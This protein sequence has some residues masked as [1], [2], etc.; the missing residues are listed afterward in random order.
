M[1]KELSYR[2]MLVV[3]MPIQ[4]LLFLVEKNILG[5]YLDTILSC[6][7]CEQIIYCLIARRDLEEEDNLLRRYYVRRWLK[8]CICCDTSH[9]FIELVYEFKQLLLTEQFL[10]KK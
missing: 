10:S 2:H 5:K 9:I 3:A 6:E 4:V 8:Q 7:H 1:K